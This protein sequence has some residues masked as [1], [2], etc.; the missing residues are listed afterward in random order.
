MRV[1]TGGG[2]YLH[3]GPED[4]SP[5]A[6]RAVPRKVNGKSGS[7]TNEEW[8]NFTRSGSKKG[9]QFVNNIFSGGNFTNANYSSAAEYNYDI[10]IQKSTHNH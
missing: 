7:T 9:M 8:N 4:F 5:K 10:P 1:D 3:S 6:L 2:E